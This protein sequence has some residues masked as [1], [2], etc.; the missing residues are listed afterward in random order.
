VVAFAA[1]FAARVR[2]LTGDPG[3]LHR[4]MADGAAKARA[5]AAPTL[6]TVYDRLGFVAVGGA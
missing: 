6:A 3:E 2:E 1:P 5:V 4:L